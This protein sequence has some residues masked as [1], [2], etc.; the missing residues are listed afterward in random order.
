MV[1]V[2]VIMVGGLESK[3]ISRSDD[4]CFHTPCGISVAFSV[5]D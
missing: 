5:L 2:S 1:L 4:F 3:I